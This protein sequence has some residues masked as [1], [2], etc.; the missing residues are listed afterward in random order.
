[1]LKLAANESREALGPKSANGSKFALESK[2]CISGRR[3]TSRFLAG[4]AIAISLLA[5]LA[6]ATELGSI[7]VLSVMQRPHARNGIQHSYYRNQPWAADFW[8]EITLA[9][10]THYSPFVVWQR[11]P[12]AGKYVNVDSNGLRRTVNPA[13]SRG[14]REVWVFGSSTLWGTGAKD[15]QTVPSILSLEYARSIGP[16]CVTNFGEAGW[17][18]TQSIIQLQ[19]AL[20]RAPDP[21]DLVLFDDGYAD[22]FP[23]Y[24][25]GKAD[26]HMDFD[27]I[28]NTLEG[29]FHRSSFDYLKETG[30]YRLITVVMNKV[31]K[32]KQDSSSAAPP[33]RD[34]DQLAGITVENYLENMKI[35]DSL[36]RG[37]GF[38][39]T[40]FWGPVLYVGNKPL[41]GPERALVAA[42]RPGEPDLCRKTYALMFSTPHPHLFDISDTF[43]HTVAD[44]Y[45][46][47]AHVTPDGNRM[48]AMRMLEMLK[49]SK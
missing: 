33:P 34:L 28:R 45:L 42:A 31:A 1:M 15:D 47:P 22:V 30:T 24:E 25:S 27:N 10:P 41:S 20:K 2:P 3:G 43:D 32:L 14:A 23:I 11:A 4:A 7:A 35:V 37:Y 5:L 36:S 18:S 48:V 38:H 19:L 17:T 16:V 13:C 9:S 21:P 29:A 12:F 40:A 39:Y 49:K 8:K 6:I 26:V 44:T 46:D